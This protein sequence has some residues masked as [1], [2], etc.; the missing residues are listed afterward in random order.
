MIQLL[1]SR[2]SVR[3]FQNKKI[4][5]QIID[6]L[7]EALLRSPSSRGINPWE[8][9]MIDDPSTMSGL[10]IAK[11]RGAEFLKDAPLGIVVCG[12]ETKSDVWI[13]DCSIASIIAQLTAQ[14]LGLGSCWVQIRNRNHDKEISAEKYVQQLLNIPS[15]MKVLSII[16][17]GYPDETPHPVPADKLEYEKVK[18]KNK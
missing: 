7:K 14:S 9:F 15:H 1:R 11:E 3:N 13:E 4:D 5:P 12:D 6:L 17:I 16:G 2:R 18:G 8:F 10:S